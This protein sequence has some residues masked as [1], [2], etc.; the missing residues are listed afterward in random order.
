MNDNEQRNPPVKDE[1]NKEKEQRKEF[2]KWVNC[3]FCIAIIALAVAVIISIALMGGKMT[4]LEEAQVASTEQIQAVEALATAHEHKYEP[5]YTTIHH[6]AVT[7]EVEH[8]AVWE[9]TI[10]YHTICTTCGEQIDGH[11]QGHVDET[12]HV[13]HNTNVPVEESHKVS[14]PWV[15]TVP[16]ADAWDEQVYA[17]TLC[18][19]CGERVAEAVVAA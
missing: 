18:S 2:K 17:G 6:D 9:K 8:P 1:A 12:G 3:A 7:E 10:G 4:Q 14:D 19:V 13:G 16:V 11:V 5:V 15:E